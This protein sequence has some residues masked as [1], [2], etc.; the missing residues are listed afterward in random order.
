MLSCSVSVCLHNIAQVRDFAYLTNVEDECF[1]V[2]DFCVCLKNGRE[3]CKRCL[4]E[5]TFFGAF[6][7]R[8]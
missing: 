2:R 6:L 3:L 8:S 4:S 1:C 5:S 7:C